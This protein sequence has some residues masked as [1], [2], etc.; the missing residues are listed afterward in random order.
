MSGSER[1]THL[2]SRRWRGTRVATP[3]YMKLLA[4]IV[5]TC[6]CTHPTAEPGVDAAGMGMGSGACG[7]PVAN[8]PVAGCVHG[9]LATISLDGMWTLTGTRSS[10]GGGNPSPVT[11]TLYIARSGSGRC[12]I[13]IES[14]PITAVPSDPNTYVD[15]TVAAYYAS[16]YYPHSY[17]NTWQLCVSA[18][19]GMLTY[20]E[21]DTVSMPMVD[22]TIDGVLSR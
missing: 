20:Q 13:A 1:R 14:A 4:A 22:T 7:G 5:L 21:H 8:A 15:D 16:G 3:T 9:G 17:S 11:E 6:A 12:A 18:T 10:F 2:I 19:T